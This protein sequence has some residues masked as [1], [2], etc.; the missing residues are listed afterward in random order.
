MNTSSLTQGSESNGVT[1]S[2]NVH[3]IATCTSYTILTEVKK[4]E[5]EPVER[6]GVEM[7]Y[8]S[9]TRYVTSSTP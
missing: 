7:L 5:D 3:Q 8:V 9:M 2:S 4:N 6:H 1:A